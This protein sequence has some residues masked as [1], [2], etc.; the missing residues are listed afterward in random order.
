MHGVLF[1]HIGQGAV[2]LIG[3]SG[4]GPQHVAFDQQPI[5]GA[6]FAALIP[7][8]SRQEGHDPG[9]GLALLIF[10]FLEAVIDLDQE[11]RLHIHRLPGLGIVVNNAGHAAFEIGFER[12]DIAVG[13]NGD[14]VVLQKRPHFLFAD[15][16]LHPGQNRLVN[17][18]DFLAHG[19][20][21]RRAF[22]AQPPFDGQTPVEGRMGL[23]RPRR[24]RDALAQQRFDG[25]LLSQGILE[26]CHPGQNM[27]F[28]R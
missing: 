8:Q 26:G 24:S 16:F 1:R 27:I 23:F 5:R 22:V 7:G 3:K 9:F 28:P 25:R 11:K 14:V 10:Q 19:K 2:D 21:L 4:F 12:E 20:K 18:A 17:A 6:D 15:E 13:R